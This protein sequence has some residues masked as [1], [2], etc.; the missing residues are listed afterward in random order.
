MKRQPFS[1][2]PLIAQGGQRGLMN[3][4]SVLGGISVAK[5]PGLKQNV[6]CNRICAQILAEKQVDRRMPDLYSQGH[7]I[8][9]TNLGMTFITR[10][11]TR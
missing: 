11:V 9:A 8:T 1:D 10:S 7:V 5:Y 3:L 4:N 6:G 2:P